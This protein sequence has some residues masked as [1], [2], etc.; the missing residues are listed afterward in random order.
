M[1]ERKRDERG[2]E[3]HHKRLNFCN[4]KKKQSKGK[5]K[6]KKKK[7]KTDAI[8]N[9]LAKVVAFFSLTLTKYNQSQKEKE[10]RK[11]ELQQF[12]QQSNVFAL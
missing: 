7:K 10:K 1:R 4:W 12:I 5:Q 11:Y 2:F 9:I 6:K 3:M 8:C